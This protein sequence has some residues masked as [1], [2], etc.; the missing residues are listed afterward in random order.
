MKPLAPW[1]LKTI[2]FGSCDDTLF[3]YFYEE[4]YGN[5]KV[6]VPKCGSM[7]YKARL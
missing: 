1:Q 7:E 4:V 3:F 2:N 6:N 5:V